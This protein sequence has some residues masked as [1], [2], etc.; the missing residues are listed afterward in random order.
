MRI[1]DSIAGAVIAVFGLFMIIYAG[2]LQAPRNLQYGAGFFPQLIGAG[3]LLVGAAIAWNGVRAL[4]GDRLWQLPDASH[5]GGWLRFA[6]IPLSILFYLVVADGL[7]FFLTAV[8]LLTFLFWAA[9]VPLRI[10]VL[11]SVIAAALFSIFFASVLH[12]PLPWGP[13]QGISG[14]LIW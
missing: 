8:V 5:P 12:M 13:L 2:T 3:L 11:V 14:W 6:A 9:K 4:S 10:G 1:N 7:G